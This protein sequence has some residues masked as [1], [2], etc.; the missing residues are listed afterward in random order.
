VV[1][2]VEIDVVRLEPREAGGKRSPDVER[3]KVSGAFLQ[4]ALSVPPENLWYPN[5]S[6]QQA[7]GVTAGNLSQVAN[8]PLGFAPEAT[9]ET[10]RQELLASGS[11]YQALDT[12]VPASA[13]RM[14][15]V[16]LKYSLGALNEGALRGQASQIIAEAA[17]IRIPAADDASLIEFASLAAAQYAELMVQDPTVCFKY[18]A[19]VQSPNVVDYPSEELIAR[20]LALN[21]KI[22]RGGGVLSASDD[23]DQQQGWDN[24]SLALERTLTADKFAVFATPV[25]EVASRDHG[26][27]AEPRRATPKTDEQALWRNSNQPAPRKPGMVKLGDVRVFH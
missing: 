2:L 19:D 3:G 27:W 10:V 4:R 18:V 20:E 23:R 12:Y 26:S 24:V 11:I 7:A 15:E 22:I 9:L 14:Y 5:A 8:L 17:R 16:A 6:E 1:E 13:A 21:E 25:G